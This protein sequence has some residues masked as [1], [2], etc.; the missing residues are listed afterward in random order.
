MV[1]S[2]EKD[3]FSLLV[4]LKEEVLVLLNKIH[5]CVRKRR[6]GHVLY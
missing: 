4:S 3:C 2:E 6:A 5:F 1:V